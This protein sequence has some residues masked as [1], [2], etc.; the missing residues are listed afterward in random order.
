MDTVFFV[1][2][3]TRRASPHLPPFPRPAGPAHGGVGSARSRPRLRAHPRR[4]KR[5][6]VNRFPR[7]SRSSARERRSYRVR[8]GVAIIT[9]G[10]G[11]ALAVPGIL[12]AFLSQDNVAP[13]TQVP[14]DQP[15]LGL[16]YS[17]LTPAKKG[18][19]CVGGYEVTGPGDCTHGP[20]APPP[21]LDV[22]HDVA[23][24]TGAVAAPQV[25]SRD[26]ATGPTEADVIGDQSTFDV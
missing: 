7:Q 16:V 4:T 5:V 19:E 20:D 9:V 11:S 23:P 3:W 2:T 10:L 25:P 14:T 8:V 26:T 22:K 13:I 21:G 12:N 17:G 24:V 18:A 6:S 15:E 1:P